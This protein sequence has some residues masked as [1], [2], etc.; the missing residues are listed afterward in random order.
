I[1][2]RMCLGFLGSQNMGRRGH[3][4]LS[5]ARLQSC[6]L[7]RPRRSLAPPFR[8]ER[9]ASP[10]LSFSGPCGQCCA[11]RRGPNAQKGGKP[12]I[13]RHLSANL[14]A[15]NWMA[16]VIELLIVIIGVFIGTQ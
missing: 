9:P 6:D 3:G 12:M 13:L 10:M 11:A 15:Q 16:I 14:R 2:G 1:K 4:A 5:Y 7:L 8:R